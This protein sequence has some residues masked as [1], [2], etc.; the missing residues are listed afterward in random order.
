MIKSMDGGAK[1]YPSPHADDEDRNYR[2]YTYG[3]PFPHQVTSRRAVVDANTRKGKRKEPQQKEAGTLKAPYLG[4]Q[5]YR[6]HASVGPVAN[7]EAMAGAGVAPEH[8]SYCDAAKASTSHG[9]VPV[10]QHQGRNTAS[11]SSAAKI[12]ARGLAI[13]SSQGQQRHSMEAMPKHA[14]RSSSDDRRQHVQ[15]VGGRGFNALSDVSTVHQHHDDLLPMYDYDN[16]VAAACMA[17]ASDPIDYRPD[18]LRADLDLASIGQ[19][20]MQRTRP[21][22]KKT[23]R[24]DKKT[25]PSTTANKRAKSSGG[26]GSHQGRRGTLP[27][28]RKTIDPIS[29]SVDGTSTSHADDVPQDR[30]AADKGVWK[31]NG[32]RARNST[33]EHNDPH[34]WAAC[35]FARI[36]T[37]ATTP[38]RATETS[39]AT[40]RQM[41]VGV[42]THRRGQGQQRQQFQQ[43]KVRRFAA[44]ESSHGSG[45]VN[46]HHNYRYAH[47][48]DEGQYE[49]S[50]RAASDMAINGCPRPSL[51]GANVGNDNLA[52]T[53]N[54]SQ[55]QDQWQLDIV[56][57][58]VA[59]ARA[60]NNASRY[61]AVS[62]YG[63]PTGAPKADYDD[64]RCSK[65]LMLQLL[66]TPNKIRN[67]KAG[68]RSSLRMMSILTSSIVTGI[69]PTTPCV[70]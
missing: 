2:S 55:G 40:E 14:G 34:G 46:G 42:I 4:D 11:L 30:R 36:S 62:P 43:K 24:A 57:D 50:E 70:P 23:P 66:A 47:P 38:T 1:C 58:S 60:D 52:S 39:R 41:D 13:D 63:A 10:A 8:A 67:P 33:D 53:V 44:Q 59:G 27:N 69:M 68:S 5:S 65:I 22:R 26:S 15:E 37:T 20:Q 32:D 16:Q 61:V 64:Q 19:V 31:V 45:A 54:A 56:P 28:Q 3:G 25:K 49:Q 48:S 18:F 6:Y 17:G 12:D 29:S 35:G 51:K 7:Q 9:Q 21:T